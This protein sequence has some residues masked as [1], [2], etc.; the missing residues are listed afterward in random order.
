MVA[1]ACSGGGG[2][3]GDDL[4]DVT[5]AALHD[6]APAL[7][8]GA[9]RGPA[10]VNLWATWCQP[11]RKELPA[12]QEVSTA[13]PDVRFVGVDI[14]EDATK[15]RDF[16]DRAGH[17]VRPVPRRP[18][19]ALRGPRH[20]RPAGDDRRRCRRQGG[21]RARR[22]DV[23]RRP[24]ARPRRALRLSTVPRMGTW[25]DHLVLAALSLDEGNR[26]VAELTGVTPAFGGVHTGRGTHNALRVARPAEL[27]RGDRPRPRPAWRR[28]GARARR[29]RRRPAAGG[30]R[31]RLRRPRRRRRRTAPRRR[32]R[33]QPIRSR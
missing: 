15:A 31:R 3:G 11:C 22:P 17:H 7:D 6:G 12:F 8:V 1:A 23:G 19:P 13:R 32:G 18:R 4:P 30:V 33:R 27:P 5:L 26:R 16:L 20:R 25:I 9:L 21:H 29:P 10:V 28:I 24:R 14:A 2:G